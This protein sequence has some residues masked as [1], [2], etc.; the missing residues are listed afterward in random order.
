M[1]VAGWWSSKVRSKNN[2]DGLTLDAAGMERKIAQD[3]LI[4]KIATVPQ[5]LATNL[6][7]KTVTILCESPQDK[8]EQNFVYHTFYHKPEVV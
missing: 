3:E 4:A 5:D 2:K 6:W 1:G 7:E 8:T